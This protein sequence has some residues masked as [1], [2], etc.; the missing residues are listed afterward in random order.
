MRGTNE[1]HPD[2]DTKTTDQ[3]GRLP[4]MSEKGGIVM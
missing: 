3:A 4:Y 2:E 1:N